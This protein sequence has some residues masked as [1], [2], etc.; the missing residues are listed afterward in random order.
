MPGG[1]QAAQAMLVLEWE[2]ICG[3]LS[4]YCLPASARS[5]VIREQALALPARYLRLQA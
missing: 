5:L 1:C 2:L 4:T 3:A